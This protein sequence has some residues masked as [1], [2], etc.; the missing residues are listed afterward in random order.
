MHFWPFV[1]HAFGPHGVVPGAVPQ[2]AG[3]PVDTSQGES[4]PQQ[5]LP[6]TVLALGQQV[7]EPPEIPAHLVPVGQ[8]LSPHACALGQQL[9]S[10][11]QL[12]SFGQHPPLQIELPALQ[13]S[14]LALLTHA[15]PMLQQFVPHC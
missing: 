11:P 10:E 9:P 4:A 3:V 6:Q 2:H 5:L 15:S 7:G 1:Q 8:Q 13:H 12:A 14:P